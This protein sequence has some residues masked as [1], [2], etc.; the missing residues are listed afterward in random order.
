MSHSDAHLLYD[1]YLCGGI[2]TDSEFDTTEEVNRLSVLESKGM[3]RR[4]GEAWRLTPGGE[5][6]AKSLVPETGKYQSDRLMK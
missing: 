2:G 4:E 5:V 6:V 1:L 3:V